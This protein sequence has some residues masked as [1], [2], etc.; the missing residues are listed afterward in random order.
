MEQSLKVSLARTP[1]PTPTPAI[2]QTLFDEARERDLKALGDMEESRANN[3]YGRGDLIREDLK[4]RG[5]IVSV[6]RDSQ[7]AAHG[8][9]WKSAR[10][11]EEWMHA[12][13]AEATRTW[14]LQLRN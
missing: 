13:T 7:E 6:G 9:R 2:P 8:T 1:R 3:Q 4:Q 10:V 12:Y 5:W 14:V 11:V